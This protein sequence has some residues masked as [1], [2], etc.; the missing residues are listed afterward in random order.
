MFLAENARFEASYR[1]SGSRRCGH[2]FCTECIG[3]VVGQAQNSGCPICRKALRI[4]QLMALKRAAPPPAPA[5]K[6]AAPAEPEELDMSAC[7]QPVLDARELMTA[8][9][10][11][12]C[13]QK[14]RTYN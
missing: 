7:P 3:A 6:P 10:E 4:D 8:G 2:L 12:L 9:G 13:W 11:G 5:G 1:D 14:K